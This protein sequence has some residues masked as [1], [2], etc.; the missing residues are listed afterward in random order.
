MLIDAHVH[1]WD[2]ERA[3]YPI[4][5]TGEL[6][7]LL[8]R[9]YVL[10]DLLRDSAGPDPG[11]VVV[12]AE[13]DHAL[14]PVGETAWVQGLADEH[15]AGD[16][17][18][19]MV[20]YA[21]LGAS[22][23][24]EILDRHLEYPLVRGVR[25]ELWW[26]PRPPRPDYR[27]SDLVPEPAFRRGLSALAARGLSFD[28]LGD[29]GQLGPLADVVATVPGLTVVVDHL[30]APPAEPAERDIWRRGLRAM[31]ASGE[32]SIKIS[33]LSFLGPEWTLDDVD[34]VFTEVL[35]IFGPARCMLGSNFPPDGLAR[36]Y[37]DVWSALE[38]LVARLSADEAADLR[39]GAARRAYRIASA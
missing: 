18:L 16:R 31:A 21:D 32:T 9:R 3:P 22:G 6:A 34:R 37:G 28:A 29:P 1:L 30:G 39:A 2:A 17:L 5:D 7:G 27:S 12:Q 26:R 36:G 8:P 13:M 35:E 33:G 24:G 15:P 38:T 19:A 4:L 10:D 14:D 20:A 23:L 25:Q 11:F